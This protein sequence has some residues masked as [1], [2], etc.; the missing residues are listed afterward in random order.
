MAPRLVLVHGDNPPDREAALEAELGR[1]LGDAP[2]ATLGRSVFQGAETQPDLL[3][4]ALTPSLFG[5][6]GAVVVMGIEECPASVN[7]VLLAG[8]PGALE[9][10]ISVLLCGE[11]GPNQTSKAGKALAKLVKEKG[12]EI[13]CPSPKLHELP[14]W[15][16][17]RCRAR[18]GRAIE[19]DAA[20]LLVE[21]AGTTD[22]RRVGE[23]LADLDRELEKIDGR[24]APGERI[25][26]ALVD[27][28]V[29]DRRPASLGDF[30]D[31]LARRKPAEAVKSMVRLREEGLP[32][33]LLAQ[34]A[35]TDFVQLYRLRRA[36]DRG[37]RPAD[38][39]SRLGINAFVFQK[40]GF[41]AAARSRTPRRW[42]S[43]IAR[44]CRIEALDKRGH[45]LNEWSLELEFH[46]VCR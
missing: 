39:A 24:L 17:N 37:E 32:G 5:D 43:D 10:G 42:L 33:F 1:A 19:K 9:S 18:F 44:L 28:L 31:A 4:T 7:E 22:F 14:R 34:S 3:A 15:V 12:S 6:V 26:F 30:L 8:I 27:E 45:F 23:T 29:G 36:L 21:R 35:W 13:G 11:K 41:E 20:A 25:P 40:R 38:A 46:L 2:E 16:E